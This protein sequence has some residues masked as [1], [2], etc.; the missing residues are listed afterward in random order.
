MTSTTSGTSAGA[1]SGTAAAETAGPHGATTAVDTST[2]AGKLE[3]L[4]LRMEQTHTPVGADAVRDLHAAG[5][6]TARERILRLL[7]PGSFVEIDAL[8]RH[9]C[10]RFGM[11]DTRPLSDGVV[12]GYGTVEGRKVCVFSQDPTVFEGQLGEVY[13]DKVIKVLELALRT[14]TPLVGIYDGTGPR[15]REGVVTLAQYARIYRLQS[16][17]SGVVPQV[18]VVTGTVRNGHVHG[19]ALSDLV[20]MVDGQAEL[21]L[22][23]PEFTRS[24]I[25]EVT[26]GAEIG[27]PELHATTTGLAHAVV[28]AEDEALDLVADL[29]SRLPSNNRAFAPAEALGPGEGVR[30]PAAARPTTADATADARLGTDAADLPPEDRALDGLI[31][32]SPAAPYDVRDLLSAVL[33][34]GSFLELQPRFAPNVIT[35][36]GHVDGRSVGVV[37]NQ[38]TELAGCLDTR[39]SD[40]AARFVR[41]CD[42]FSVPVRFVVDTPGFLP[43]RA[44]E[45]AGTVLSSSKLIHAVAETTVGT[46]TLVTRK[47]FG[48]AYVAMGAKDLG[49]DMVFA[50]PTAQ[51]SVADAEDT[52]TAVYAQ[53]IA[54]VREAEGVD[55]AEDLAAELEREIATT[56]VTPYL[57]AERGYVD[58][59]IAPHATRGRLR[60]AFGL[61]ERKLTENPARK[62]GNIP[63]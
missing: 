18:A 4:R 15:I 34:D 32:D 52:T 60:D 25:G 11:E 28:G 45:S 20:I 7:D 56:V 17:M 50:W 12:T 59:V 43:G 42:A 47:A 27:G 63:L 40:K 51:I 9:R 19:P 41:L 36:F 53:R 1:T 26:T 29:L 46:A 44:E 14:G 6:M 54:E 24:V 49:V 8:A 58:A 21:S 5:R 30:V 55:A 22:S 23:D 33:D 62:H 3:D 35:G 13:G 31:P 39:A 48:S 57:A 2:T 37:A 16:Q 38:P 10:T 61:L